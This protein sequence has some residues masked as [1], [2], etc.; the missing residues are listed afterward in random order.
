MLNKPADQ[1]TES[2]LQRLIS[3][4]VSERRNIDYERELPGST[5][6]DKKEFLADVSSFANTAGGYLVFGMVESGG[7]PVQVS[8]TQAHNTDAEGQ[9][10]DSILTAGIQP[11]IRYDL[12]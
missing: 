10:I 12:A 5:D 8:G 11:R 9:R 4:G 6:K 2:D 3:D 7:L 1:I